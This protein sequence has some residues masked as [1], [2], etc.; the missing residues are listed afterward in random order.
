[1]QTTQAINALGA[2]AQDICLK[3]FRILEQRGPEGLTAGVLAERLGVPGHRSS[4]FANLLY[5]WEGFILQ[6]IR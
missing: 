3:I 2:L 5:G 6:K 1:M 4:V